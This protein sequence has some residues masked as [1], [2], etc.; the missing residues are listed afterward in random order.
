MHHKRDEATW[1]PFRNLQR[2]DVL[3]MVNDFN[4]E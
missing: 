1:E 3:A 4:E 2:V